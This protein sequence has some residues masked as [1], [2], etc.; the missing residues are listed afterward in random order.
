MSERVS[1]RVSE[2]VTTREAIA[3]KNIGLC[4]H[5]INHAMQVFF[6]VIFLGFVDA[7][8]MCILKILTF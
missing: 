4:F 2:K 1:E 8:V 5:K 7:P 3:S 6:K